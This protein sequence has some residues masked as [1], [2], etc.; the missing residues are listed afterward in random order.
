MRLG[1]ATQAEQIAAAKSVHDNVAR[2][3][4]MWMGTWPASMYREQAQQKLESP[5]GRQ[6]LLKIVDDALNAAE[7]V[8]NAAPP[9]PPPPSQPPV[10]TRA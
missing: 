10:Q 9:P 5:E 8:R 7:K 3:I 4:D 6:V 1:Q 2:M